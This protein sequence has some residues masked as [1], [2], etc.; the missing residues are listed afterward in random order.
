MI[1]QKN[2]PGESP[3]KITG[4]IT[5]KTEMNN[6]PVKRQ[7]LRIHIND[8]TEDCFLAIFSLLINIREKLRLR[9]VCKRWM[10]IIE[11]SMIY[12]HTRLTRAEE[13]YYESEIRSLQSSLDEPPDELFGRYRIRLSDIFASSHNLR[14]FHITKNVNCPLYDWNLNGQTELKR[15]ALLELRIVNDDQMTDR[16]LATLVERC[17]K[18]ETVQIV[19]CF[20]V[21]GDF[22]FHIKSHLK[23]LTLNHCQIVGD[24]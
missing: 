18:L 5:K 12:H 13:V 7:Y 16:Q 8:L 24:L 11:K 15:I 19:N 9:A 2:R 22:L 4:Q 10:H 23:N 21:N 17:P 14:V 1:A 20:G 6:L 3:R